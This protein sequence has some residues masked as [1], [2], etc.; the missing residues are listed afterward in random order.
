MFIGIGRVRNSLHVSDHSIV[1][2]EIG[3]LFIGISEI[4]PLL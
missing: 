1:F 4:K 2:I 3:K